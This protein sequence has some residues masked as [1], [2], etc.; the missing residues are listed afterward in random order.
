MARKHRVDVDFSELA[1]FRYLHFGSEWIQGGMQIARPWK[2]AL[3][4]QQWMMTLMLFN[5]KPQNILQLGLGAG[6]FAKFTW[7]YFPEAHTKVV[8]ISEDVFMAARMW[9]RL[10]DPDDRWEII[11]RD[12]KRYLSDK[13][14]LVPADW[15]LVDIYDAECWGPVYNDVPFYRLCRKALSDSGYAT[16]NVFGGE[17]FEVSYSAIS[18]AFRGRVLATPE[19]Q[20]GNKIII[21]SNAPKRTWKVSELKEKAEWIRKT[22]HIPTKRWLEGLIEVNKLDKN[23]FVF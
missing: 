16:F 14:E 2:L 21:A 3:E 5:D 10:P 7:K 23:E 18:E 20:E 6:G 17:D 12:C 9:F 1:G 22:Y 8:E 19:V 13:D 4:Y 11:F 15:M